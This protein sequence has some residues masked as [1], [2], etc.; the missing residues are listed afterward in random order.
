MADQHDR[1]LQLVDSDLDTLLKDDDW[2]VYL[3]VELPFGVE[4]RR[5]ADQWG[6]IPGMGHSVVALQR[7]PDG[8]ILIADPSVGIERWTES[9]LRL[10]WHGDGLR[11]K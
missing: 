3:A 1:T 2:P 11:V 7:T 6:W 4:D 8:G 5:Y 10:L 9:D